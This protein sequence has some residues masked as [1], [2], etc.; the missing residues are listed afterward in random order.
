NSI[1]ITILKWTIEPIRDE[2]AVNKGD[3]ES[4]FESATH[5]NINRAQLEVQ[6]ELVNKAL[7]AVIPKATDIIASVQ[8]PRPIGEIQLPPAFAPRTAHIQK[9][10]SCLSEVG[11]AWVYGA[12]GVGKTFAAKLAARQVGGNWT[13][14]N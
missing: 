9:I 13:F 12:A 6:N 11:V 8:L 14:V 3:L 4:L 10:I 2:R 1:L 7:S 5:V